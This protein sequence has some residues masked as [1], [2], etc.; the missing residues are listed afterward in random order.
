MPS[1]DVGIGNVSFSGMNKA[2]IGLV[3]TFARPSEFIPI[4]FGRGLK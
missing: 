1:Y 4:I 2:K 3:H